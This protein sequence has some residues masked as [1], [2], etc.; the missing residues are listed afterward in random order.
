MLKS[1]FQGSCQ[2]CGPYNTRRKLWRRVAIARIYCCVFLAFFVSIFLPRCNEMCSQRG[3]R[4]WEQPALL[5]RCQATP[6]R[7]LGSAWQQPA[8]HFDV[9]S[10]PSASVCHYCVW[11]KHWPGLGSWKPPRHSSWRRGSVVRTSVFCWW[12][13]PDLW[14]TCNHFVG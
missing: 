13:F 8:Y 10:T 3:C 1:A 7:V 5:G 14:L 6:Y 9:I 2:N 4:L 12:T 11:G